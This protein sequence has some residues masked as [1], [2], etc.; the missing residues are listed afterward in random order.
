[1]RQSQRTKI[2]QLP[3]SITLQKLKRAKLTS[4]PEENQDCD[5]TRR[6]WPLGDTDDAEDNSNGSRLRYSCVSLAILSM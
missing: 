5:D 1:M 2:N 6:N 3:L 4:L